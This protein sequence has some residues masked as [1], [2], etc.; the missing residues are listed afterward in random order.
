MTLRGPRAQQPVLVALMG[1]YPG[2]E[3]QCP[4]PTPLLP[5]VPCLSSGSPTLAFGVLCPL[6]QCPE[7]LAYT[8]AE[9]FLLRAHHRVASRPQQRLHSKATRQRQPDS[10]GLELGP[11][12]LPLFQQEWFQGTKGKTV[13]GACL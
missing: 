3:Q 2:P 1:A 5:P 13:K 12:G 7:G 4:H 11:G 8:V 9:A 10:L 6:G